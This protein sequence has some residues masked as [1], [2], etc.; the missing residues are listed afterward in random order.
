M[1]TQTLQKV[2]NDRRTALGESLTIMLLRPLPA[3]LPFT[4]LSHGDDRPVEL[5][6]STFLRNRHN[7]R[8]LQP[9]P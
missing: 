9:S 7:G 1:Q 4:R 8:L 5:F 6:A 3:K 2:Y